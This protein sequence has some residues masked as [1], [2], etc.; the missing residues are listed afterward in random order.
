[1]SLSTVFLSDI[2]DLGA[3]P[4]LMI[5]FAI[6]GMNKIIETANEI[7]EQERKFMIADFFMA[8]LMFIPMSG[9]TPG[10][11]GATLLRT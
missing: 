1:M 7:I 10:T 11:L 5:Q 8:F 9:V 2:V 6:T 3:L 4:A